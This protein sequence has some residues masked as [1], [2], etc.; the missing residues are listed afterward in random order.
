MRTT[1][2][3]LVDRGLAPVVSPPA[4]RLVEET[5]A[6]ETI[7]DLLVNG[8]GSI[9]VDRGL[10]VEPTG[11]AI[12]PPSAV[13]AVAVRLAASAHRRLDDNQ[14]WVDGIL[15]SGARLHAV[16]P[17]LA[18]G[19]T[20]ISLRI[21]RREAFSLADLARTGMIDET[22]TALLGSLIQQR[23]SFVIT[24]G[25][26][27]G[28]STLLA[29]MLS[30]VPSRERIVLVEDVKEIVVDH[31]QVVRLQARPPNVEGRGGVTLVDLVRQALRMRP[32]RL[33]VGEVRGAE[34][35][36][37][38]TALNTGHE[39]GAG[40]VHAN[41]PDDVVARFESLGALAGM[42][43]AAVRTQLGAAVEAVV[44]VDRVDGRRRLHSVSAVERVSDDVHIREAWVRSPG[45]LVERPGGTL[46]TARGVTAR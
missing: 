14:P 41:R 7:T 15:P 8:D 29:A 38:L 21:P 1:E 26:G 17:P 30:L 27:S 45:G 11:A 37:L 13:R 18:D 16:L 31:P 10:G 6:D 36:E 33:V 5:L 4:S 40:T 24:G 44:H 32:D 22:G 9:W 3:R 28:K 34:A 20:L 2:D 42:S 35:R 25:T 23:C 12:T 46:L 19:G 43:P 39:G